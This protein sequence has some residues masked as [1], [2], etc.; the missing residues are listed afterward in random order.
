MQGIS[1]PASQTFSPLFLR[2]RRVPGETIWADG[3]PNIRIEGIFPAAGFAAEHMPKDTHGD[4]SFLFHGFLFHSWYYSTR[5][6]QTYVR[7]KIFLF[8]FSC[9]EPGVS[10]RGGRRDL[11]GQSGWVPGTVPQRP[12]GIQA[13][14]VPVGAG[15]LH[16]F[17]IYEKIINTKKSLVF[18][19]HRPAHFHAFPVRAAKPVPGQEVWGDLNCSPSKALTSTRFWISLLIFPDRH[20]KMPYL[21]EDDKHSE[22]EN[23]LRRSG[24]SVPADSKVRL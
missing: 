24:N 14:S 13:R 12:G 21:K 17:S 19:R 11:C 4:S 15:H 22:K 18:D 3:V 6:G 8:F 16:N 7:V 20:G 1:I 5:P 9:S 2:E 10:G 23:G